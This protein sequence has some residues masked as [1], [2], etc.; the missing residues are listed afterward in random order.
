MAV[1]SIAAHGSPPL[2]SSPQPQLKRT[3]DNDGDRDSGQESAAA[4]TAEAVTPSPNATLG[5]KL[6][7]TS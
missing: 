1:T 4:K 2:P 5:Q 6:N 7:I 3:G